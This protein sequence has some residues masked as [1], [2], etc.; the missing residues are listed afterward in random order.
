MTTKNN[1]NQE[2]TAQNTAKDEPF[3]EFI[4]TPPESTPQAP[5]PEP[6][7]EE[8]YHLALQEIDRLKSEYLRAHA[9]AENVKRRALK[10]IEDY[11]KYAVA[12]LAREIFGVADTL[13]SAIKAITPDSRQ[14][15]KNLDNLAFGLEMTITMFN[16]AFGRVAIKQAANIGGKFDPNFH[17]AVS[18]TPANEAN[19]SGTITA[20]MQQGFILHDRLLR[21]AMVIVAK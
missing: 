15:D 10:D 1:Q 8:K 6:T 9:D 19:P 13:F 21:P 18:E 12:P 11:K 7:I 14:N 5:A 16:E 20:I 17:Q 3:L 4:D 2:D